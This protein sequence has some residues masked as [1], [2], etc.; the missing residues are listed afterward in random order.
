MTESKLNFEVRTQDE[1]RAI[2]DGV[3]RNPMVPM[4][5][6]ITLTDGSLV[7]VELAPTSIKTESRR[8]ISTDWYELEI[9]AR[10]V[11]RI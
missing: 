11:Q 2:V 1:Q 5:L 9:G 7:S 6:T 10:Q 4:I 3:C 8:N